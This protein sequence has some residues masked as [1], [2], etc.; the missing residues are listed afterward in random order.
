MYK[1]ILITGK[2]QCGKSTLINKIL[3]ELTDSI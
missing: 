1:N 2:V 3:N